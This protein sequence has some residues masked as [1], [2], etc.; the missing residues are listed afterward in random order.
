MSARDD[1][2]PQEDLPPAYDGAADASPD[3]T[4]AGSSASSDRVD[5]SGPSAGDIAPP[6]RGTDDLAPVEVDERFADIVAGFD[7][8]GSDP[9]PR[10]SVLE[11]SDEPLPPFEPPPRAPLSSRLLRSEPPP[12]PDPDDLVLEPFVPEPPPPL[13]EIDRATR[14]A[15]AGLIGGPVLLLVAS[16]VGIGMQPW[17]VMVAL[18]GFVGGFGTLIARMGDGPDDGDDGAVV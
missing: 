2:V 18:G 3:E 10:W 14:M 9:V 6:A 8:P 17:V 4:D 16:L 7:E 13:P 1:D 12:A 11:D 5:P 15:W